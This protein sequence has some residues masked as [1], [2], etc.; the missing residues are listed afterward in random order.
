MR[1][2]ARW[3]CAHLPRG[4]ALTQCEKYTEM[5]SNYYVVI[6][7]GGV[8]VRFWPVSR[9]AHPKQFIDILGKG[10]SLL[11]QT[12]ERFSA[13]CP[14][15]NIYVVT[16]LDYRDLVR[17]Q[18]PDIK[19]EHILCEPY[20]KNTA[21]CI[22]YAN[23]KIH[24]RNPKATVV[25]APS[26]HVV[27]KE[28]VFLSALHD[29]AA[30]ATQNPW[31]VTLGI[32]PS[33]PNTGYGYIQ[34]DDRSSNAAHPRLKKVKLFTEKPGYEMARSFVESGEFLWNAG[35]FIWSLPTI[36]AA[37]HQH[38]PEI[39]DL[40]ATYAHCLD[41]EGEA[42]GIEKTYVSCRNISIDY[43]VMEKADNVYV[44][45]CDFGWS[46]VGSWNS[47]Y[48]LLPKNA[49][50]NAVVGDAAPMLY[51][52]KGNLVRVPNGKVVVLQGMEDC[53]VVEDQGVLL[54][55]KRQEEQRIRQFVEDV[56]KEKG[57][58]YV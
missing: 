49:E 28:D 40:F 16:N 23:Y 35:I 20:R 46:D 45:A 52:S 5:N 22:A 24:K 54:I 3:C 7:A 48:E 26:D 36:M 58:Q 56:T 19:P 57:A 37:F 30:A 21:P 47:L 15:E 13:F 4:D 18:L 2:R 10:K 41:T 50:G 32:Q 43:G 31:L 1:V 55:C 29:A 6:M 39:D 17:E 38:L 27:Q 53:I 8:G 9:S 34:F 51:E 11:Q 25:V 14:K 42:E 12:F 33:Y 44:V